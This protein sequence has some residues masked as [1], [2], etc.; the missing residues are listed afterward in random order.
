MASN[1]FRL[2][3]PL[4]DSDK[5]DQALKGYY[6][7]WREHNQ[8]SKSPF[9]ALDNSFRDKH[10]SELEPGPLRLYLYFS[11]AAQNDYG[12]SWHS[13]QKMSEFFNTQT[14][15]IDNWL[16]VLVEKELI[17]RKQ[18][19]NKSHTTYL[20]PFSDTLIKHPTPKKHDHDNQELLEDLI[21]KIK[22]QAFIYGDI[23][24]VFH[25][26]Q[27]TSRKG[28]PISRENSVQLLL[29]ITKRNNG[30][31]IGHI[32]SLRKSEH[33]SVSQ[34]SIDEPSIFESPFSFDQSNVIG[35]ALP[36][37]P[38]LLTKSAIKDT[39]V[40]VKELAELEAWKIEDR[41][42]LEYG[43]KDEVLPVVDEEST[44]EDTEETKDEEGDK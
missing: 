41:Q 21:K 13:I 32:Y 3:S 24:N 18:K 26:F 29:I 1:K 33:L 38:P 12:H 2:T 10:L 25:L 14:R 17:Y 37:F 9:M 22:E 40:L 36:P 30:V 23:L 27:W 8:E 6:K 4:S 44:L 15:T 20:L 31:L 35:L 5:A 19:G 39:L 11:F 34:L 7:S 42:K 16:K 28:K 43:I